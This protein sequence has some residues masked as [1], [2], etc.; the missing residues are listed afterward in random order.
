MKT[1]N[2][3][4]TLFKASTHGGGLE[5]ASRFTRILEQSKSLRRFAE[6][7]R[8]NQDQVYEFYYECFNAYRELF[9]ERLRH[10][11]HLHQV[12]TKY[13]HI[14]EFQALRPSEISR[15]IFNSPTMAYWFAFMFCQAIDRQVV[16]GTIDQTE[17]QLEITIMSYIPSAQTMEEILNE[18]KSKE[19]AA[20]PL[21]SEGYAG[22]MEG[23]KAAV[24]VAVNG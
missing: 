13:R 24:R 2:T 7:E 19:T 11:R 17:L 9:M 8:M 21:L 4:S 23:Q 6:V 20:D 22:N 14:P 15:V 12:I 18:Q 3:T 5:V 10:G 16:A 1:E